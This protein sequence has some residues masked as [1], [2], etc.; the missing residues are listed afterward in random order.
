M[1]QEYI[2]NKIIGLFGDEIASEFQVESPPWSHIVSRSHLP[3]TLTKVP[4]SVSP[5]FS[6]QLQ[7]YQ[8]MYIYITSIFLG[9]K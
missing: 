8:P 4:F 5:V 6:A 9:K 7:L 2:G 3:L 1:V